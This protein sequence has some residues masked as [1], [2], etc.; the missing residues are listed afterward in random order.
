M[1]AVMQPVTINVV[2]FNKAIKTIAKAAGVK[3]M[4]VMVWP[5][6]EI[7]LDFPPPPDQNTLEGRFGEEGAKAIRAAGLNPERVLWQDCADFYVL[8]RMTADGSRE[9]AR[10][11]ERHERT[12]AREFEK[13]LDV[14]MGGEIRYLAVGAYEK[15]ITYDPVLQPYLESTNDISEEGMANA[16]ERYS[17][18]LTWLDTPDHPKLIRASIEPLLSDLWGERTQI[19]GPTW[20]TVARVL[21]DWYD[22]K[23]SRRV[24]VDRCFTMQHNNGAVFNKAYRSM[25]KLQETLA[26]QA[27]S[28]DYS[29]LAKRCSPAVRELWDTTR[30][31]RRADFDAEWLGVQEV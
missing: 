5:P 15:G 1:V 24:F 26:M 14:A 22:G 10:L 8:E 19:A 27:A 12:L 2:D 6:N 17:S 13:Y 30:H 7:F 31:E 29:D 28:R 16:H 25:R 9:A 23:I 18:W 21:M 20:G 3:H 4:H 11:L